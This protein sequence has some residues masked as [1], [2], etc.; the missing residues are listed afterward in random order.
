MPDIVNTT[1]DNSSDEEQGNA[2][3]RQY[4]RQFTKKNPD[5]KKKI[6]KSVSH[7]GVKSSLNSYFLDQMN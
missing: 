7:N 4:I 6:E 3:E 5:I 2:I 1:H